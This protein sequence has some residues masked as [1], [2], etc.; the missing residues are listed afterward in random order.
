MEEN[1]RLQRT[2]QRNTREKQMTYTKVD[3]WN[4]LAE[5][6]ATE[7]LDHEEIREEI[8]EVMNKLESS[9]ECEEIVEKI[10]KMN[11]MKKN[12]RKQDPIL[13]P[14]HRVIK[15]IRECL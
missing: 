4:D 11:G 9:F 10:K 15:V 2:P 1:R 12:D 3:A 8:T 5:L 6:R 14:R 7:G 13:I